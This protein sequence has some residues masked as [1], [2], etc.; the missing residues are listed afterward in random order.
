MEIMARKL[1][2]NN[3]AC[4]QFRP[5]IPSDQHYIRFNNGDGCS[6]PVSIFIIYNLSLISSEVEQMTGLVSIISLHW[7][8]PD[9]LQMH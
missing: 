5:R 6:S 3:V 9:A 8:I 4:I 1:A 2:L 7:N